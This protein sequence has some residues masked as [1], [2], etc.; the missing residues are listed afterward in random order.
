[1]RGPRRSAVNELEEASKKVY[2]PAGGDMRGIVG[3]TSNIG[4]CSA[5]STTVMEDE[6][7]N[8][9]TGSVLG[10]LVGWHAESWSASSSVSSSTA[11]ASNARLRAAGLLCCD[12][13]SSSES[14][15]LPY[16]PQRTVGRPVVWDRV[17]L[18]ALDA[19]SGVEAGC[20]T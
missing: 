16:L 6:A 18:L 15:S 10:I 12:R 5:S 19:E 7:G 14:S 3:E 8:K 4:G 17:I 1:M 13:C 11:R 20:S 9:G 2:S